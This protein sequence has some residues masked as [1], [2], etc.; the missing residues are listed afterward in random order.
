VSGTVTSFC[1]RRNEQ[2]AFVVRFYLL[3]KNT[4]LGQRSDSKNHFIIQFKI[5]FEIS[6][7]ERTFSLLL[8]LESLSGTL[9]GETLVTDELGADSLQVGVTL[10]LHLLDTIAVSLLVY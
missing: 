10:G 1:E 7:E 6:K 8:V 3:S 2:D 9:L 4:F 5:H